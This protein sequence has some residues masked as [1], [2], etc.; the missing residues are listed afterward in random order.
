MPNKFAPIER[1]HFRGL[2]TLES[3]TDVPEGYSPDCRN[4]AFESGRVFKRP[5]TTVFHSSNA[6]AIVSIKEY[7]QLDTTQRRLLTMDTN[8]ALMGEPGTGVF[9]LIA[10]DFVEATLK[11][12]LVMNSV[13]MFGREYMA[14]SQL[15]QVGIARPRQYDGTNLDPVAPEGPGKGPSVTTGA[16]DAVLGLTAGIHKVRQF[17]KTRTGFW[18]TLS[19]PTEYTAPGGSLVNVADLAIGPEWVT[20]RAIVFTPEGSDDYYFIEGSKMDVADNTT[21]A[22][23]GIGWGTDDV[24]ISGTPVSS[25]VDPSDDL[26]RLVSLPAQAGVVTF[27]RRVGYW[28][29]RATFGRANDEGFPNLTFNGGVV[30]AVPNVPL[31][32]TQNTIYGGTI[33]SMAGAVGK[34]YK[35]TGGLGSF[36]WPTIDNTVKPGSIFPAGAAVRARARVR[37]SA[38]AI[39][40]T[41]HVVV[42]DPAAHSTGPG[43]LPGLMISAGDL[44]DSEWRVV[45]GEIL[46]AGYGDF[47]AT[48][49]LRISE[50]GGG[51]LYVG[52]ELPDGEWIAIDE[53]EVYPAVD[54]ELKSQIRWSKTD[55]AEAFDDLYGRQFIAENNGQDIRCVFGVRESCYVAKENSLYRIVH[56][57][58]TE[59]SGWGADEVSATVGTSSPS[60][61]GHGDGWVVIAARDGLQW[62]AGSGFVNLTDEIAPT[63]ARINQKYAHTI[64]VLVNT[65]AR[66]IFVAVPLDSAV[67]PNTLLYCGYAG[68]SPADPQYRDWSIWDLPVSSLGFSRRPD[69]S[70]QVYAGTNSPVAASFLLQLNADEVDD[71]V[72]V[73]SAAI[74]AYYRT[75]YVGGNTGRLLFGYM[76]A[77]LDGL[78]RILTTAHNREADELRLATKYLITPPIH[79][80]EWLM[81]VDGARVAFQFRTTRLGEYF[82]LRKLALFAKTHPW[83]KIRGIT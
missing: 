81:N 29:E 44:S 2:R 33:E 52:S 69:G 21:N 56:N 16:V 26:L 20:G 41:V 38:G 31:G 62:F 58:D 75:D 42:V 23:T 57:P 8:G 5:G 28:G 49:V 15:G 82:E 45:D 48:W 7:V 79:D 67:R 61:V 12:D 73:T 76:T 77:E 34:V 78:G 46:A 13:T 3:P 72:G 27:Q 80:E 25:Q 14:F 74:D 4:V 35:I 65:E 60:G 83:T 22:V 59:P 47:S 43:Y 1:D 36:D 9:G 6:T 37:R 40:G 39:G 70:R 68:T 66:E 11:G 17:F 55:D 10:D 71:Y 54:P 30:A 50:G 51:G 19:P 64:R 32:W 53:L 63:W 18:T 24:L